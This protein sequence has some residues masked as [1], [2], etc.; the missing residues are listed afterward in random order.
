MQEA[1]VFAA[2]LA[3]F[4][5]FQRMPG[6]DERIE[7]RWVVPGKSGAGELGEPGST[8]MR[9]WVRPKNSSNARIPNSGHLIPQEAPREL[10]QEVDMF[11]QRKYKGVR[12]V[13]S[14][15]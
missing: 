5:V 2:T 12:N 13:K 15:L 7:L 10:A 11:I 6:L 4:E 3:Q 8:H 14:S 1:V 9:V